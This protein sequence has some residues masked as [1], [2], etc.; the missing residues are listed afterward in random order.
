M[1]R[2]ATHDS[3]DALVR[4]T[5]RDAVRRAAQD[6]TRTIA[7]LAAAEL[8]ARLAAGVP[9]APSRRGAGRRGRRPARG[10]LVRWAADRS[11]RRVPTFVIELTGLDTKKKIVGRY[12]D[13]AAFEKGK[14]APK[15]K[16]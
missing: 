9:V 11:A 14:P 5:T 2:L 8:T 10:E 7:E 1:P 16:G 15:P 3:I 4:E 12:G 6:I 13:G